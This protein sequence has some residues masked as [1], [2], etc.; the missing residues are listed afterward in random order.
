MKK[1]EKKPDKSRRNFLKKGALLPLAAVA[2]TE[3]AE[4]GEF[5]RSHDWY[6]MLYDATKCIGCKSCMVAC[7]RVNGMPP[8]LDEEGLHDA[9]ID[10][11][12]KT[13]NIIKLYEGED[14]RSF[15]KRQCMHCLDPSCVSA[16]PVSAMRKDPKTGIVYWDGDNCIGCRY[17]MMACPFEIPKFEW[18]SPFPKIVKCTLCKDTNLKEKGI[19]ACCEVCPTGAIIFG[20]RDELLDIAKHRIKDNPG[21]Y[22]PEVYGEY[23]VGGTGVLYLSHINFT[24]LGLP[25][26]PEESPAEYCERIHHGIYRTVLP[27][28]LSFG[29]IYFLMTRKHNNSEKD[30][31]EKSHE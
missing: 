21:R 16:C 8:D 13:M 10:L 18:D 28:F 6:G 3:G 20:N 4:A 22:L 23:E 17:C 12:S 9:P 27:P 11:D 1:R 24:K 5:V 29:V 26:L 14:G 15:V 19:P 7:K 25:D 30:E 2:L 31:K